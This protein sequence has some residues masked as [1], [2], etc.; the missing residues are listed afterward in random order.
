MLMPPASLTE[1][2]F[3]QNA[4][5]SRSLRAISPSP[6]QGHRARDAELVALVKEVMCRAGVSRVDAHKLTGREDALDALAMI[7][8]VARN[9]EHG[10]LAPMIDIA[11]TTLVLRGTNTSELLEMPK[12]NAFRVRDLGIVRLPHAFAISSTINNLRA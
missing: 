6:L 7:A 3:P 5:F 4:H 9:N 12:V 10:E 8:D 2:S 1:N 11:V